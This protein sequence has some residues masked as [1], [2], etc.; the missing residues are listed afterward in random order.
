MNTVNVVNK[1]TKPVHKMYHG[2]ILFVCALLFFAFSIGFPLHKVLQLSLYGI[3]VHPDIADYYFYMDVCTIIGS[4]LMLISLWLIIPSGLYYMLNSRQNDRDARIE[5]C[6]KS[7]LNPDKFN[8]DD[9][10]FL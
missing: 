1:N 3:V 10:P 6:R 7:S 2:Y 5:Y 9:I 4:I 8:P